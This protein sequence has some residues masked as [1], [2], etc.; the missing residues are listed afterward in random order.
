MISDGEQDWADLRAITD[1]EGEG[2]GP[3][4]HHWNR[5]V[6]SFETL[7]RQSCVPRPSAGSLRSVSRR[8]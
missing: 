3:I 2:N 4:S 8:T 7:I 5:W 1:F 6:Y